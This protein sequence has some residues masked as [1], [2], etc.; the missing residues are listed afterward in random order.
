MRAPVN[1]LVASVERDSYGRRT[2]AVS[3]PHAPDLDLFEGVSASAGNG[4][5]LTGPLSPTNAAALRSTVDNLRPRPLGVGRSMGTGDRLGLAT[6][7][8]VRAFQR[9]GHGV[10]PVFAQQSIREMDRLGRTAQEVLDDATFGCVEAEWNGAVGADTDH[11]KT[12]EGIDR[13]LDAGFTTFTLDPG[14]H[15]VDPD[16]ARGDISALVPW[17]SLEDD[18]AALVRRYSG[19]SISV[20]GT[21]LVITEDQLLRGAVKYGAA[22]ADTVRLSRHLR[23]R[24]RHDV[25]IEVAID[26]TDLV[27]SVAE[28]Y[29]VAAE[30]QR[31]G[32]DWVSFAPRYADGFEKGVEYLGRV[33]DLAV[34]LRGHAAVAEQLGGYKISLHSGSDKFSIYAAA[35]EAT[36]GHIHLKTSG[37][38]Y[39]SALEVVAL[40]EPDLLREMYAVSRESYRRSRATYQVSADVDSTPDPG[41]VSDGEL[42]DLVATFDSR[43]IL[44]VGYGDVLTATD[45]GGN[46]YLDVALREVLARHHELYAD[47]LADHLGRHLEPFAG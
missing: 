11:I 42:Q 30:L 18:P 3:T 15:V 44:H 20:A 37:T 25:E 46:R 14:D 12:T 21:P 35:V 9:H 38:S 39:L 32:V 29:Y 24:A 43:Q 26:E 28:H 6:P 13:G 33:D 22:V 4:Y 41:A 16:T 34:N 45:R 27:T 17:G 2:L 36:G 19:T 8:H 47:I 10:T 1:Q 31:L 23:E 40:H 7:G 5:Q